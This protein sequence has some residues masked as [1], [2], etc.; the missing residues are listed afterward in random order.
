MFDN[1]W[2]LDQID[3]ANRKH[4]QYQVNFWR[5]KMRESIHFE[6]LALK[7]NYLAECLQTFPFAR[8]TR[9]ANNSGLQ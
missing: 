5:I 3:S 7:D 2:E 1:E 8:K 4:D 6:I 9:M